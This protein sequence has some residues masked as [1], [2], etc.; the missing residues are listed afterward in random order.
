MIN[1]VFVPIAVPFPEDDPR[2]A[3]ELM[4]LPLLDAYLYW[5]Y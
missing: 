2:C 4:R 1:N 5:A 3:Q